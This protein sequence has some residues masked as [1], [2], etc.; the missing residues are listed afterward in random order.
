MCTLDMKRTKLGR[1]SIMRE[2]YKRIRN[3]WSAFGKKTV[4][5][6]NSVPFFLEKENV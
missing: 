3:V 4:I 2:I 5:L 6:K 1:N